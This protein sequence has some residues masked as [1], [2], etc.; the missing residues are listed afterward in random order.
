MD[1]K[2]HRIMNIVYILIFNSTFRFVD[3]SNMG[4]CDEMTD[5]PGTFILLVLST[6]GK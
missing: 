1:H 3:R 6:A 5:E 4:K 2:G